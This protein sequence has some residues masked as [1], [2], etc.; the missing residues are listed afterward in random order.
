MFHYSVLPAGAWRICAYSIYAWPIWDSTTGLLE[1]LA[2]H[3]YMV[4]S[5]DTVLPSASYNGLCKTK[6][7]TKRVYE[8]V[9][10]VRSIEIFCSTYITFTMIC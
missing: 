7:L 6:V 5:M 10:W 3:G 4:V 2:S 9:E 1:H 8:K